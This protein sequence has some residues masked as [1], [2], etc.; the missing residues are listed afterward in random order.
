MRSTVDRP[1]SNAQPP[2]RRRRR[3]IVLV[4][5]VSLLVLAG[6]A[7]AGIWWFLHGDTP[8][9]VSLQSATEQVTATTDR[10]AS[11]ASTATT[12]AA[13]ATTTATSGSS[14]ASA[15]AIA[16]TWT[17]DTSVG[18]FSF[19]DSTGT[20][21]GFRVDEQL[22]GIGSTT[23]VGRTPDVSGTV[24]IDGT[25]V[26]AAKIEADLSSITTN[27]SRRNGRVQEALDTST[28]PTATFVLTQPIDLGATAA[29][30]Q[31]VTVDATGELTIHGVTKTVTIPLQ[32]QLVNGTVVIVGSM[33]ITFADYGVSV[34]S[35]A[36]VLSVD[37]HGTLELQ[38]FLQQS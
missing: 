3:R 36:I 37:D 25:T 31:A 12:A 35:S 30:G 26:T 17:V 1:P 2:K 9:A 34:P 15:S 33:P 18:E 10:T 27:D 28:Y 13:T 32:T 29:D 24:T 19:E 14:S 21:V 6:A 7:G 5:A 20:F 23:A 38:L 22:S 16:G 4:V 8:D 11:T